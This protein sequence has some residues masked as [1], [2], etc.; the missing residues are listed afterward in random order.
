MKRTQLPGPLLRKPWYRE[1]S[2]QGIYRPSAIPGNSPVRVFSIHP[3]YIY[4]PSAYYV[5][6]TCWALHGGSEDVLVEPVVE[7]YQDFRSNVG[8]QYY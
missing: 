2:S 6:S 7:R 8:I 1:D 5:P 4:L 3:C